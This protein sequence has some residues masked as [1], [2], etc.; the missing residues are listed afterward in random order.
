MLGGAWGNSGLEE[1]GLRPG[2]RTGFSVIELE[3]SGF[4]GGLV[5]KWCKSK[6]S[7]FFF[8]AG[9]LVNTDEEAGFGD[10]LRISLLRSI[11]KSK[12]LI[13]ISGKGLLAAGHAG[14][15][16][17]LVREPPGCSGAEDVRQGC[18]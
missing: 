17:K 9:K 6:K 13:H 14:G 4:C 11:L 3:S 18:I 8:A 1:L 15:W 7:R 10:Q 16:A 5:A 12:C 2:L